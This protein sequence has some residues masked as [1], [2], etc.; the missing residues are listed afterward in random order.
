[1][2]V[3]VCLFVWS[4]PIVEPIAYQSTNLVQIRYLGSS[5]KY[6]ESFFSFSPTPKIKGSSYEKK[7]YK[8]LFSQKRLQR[9]WLNFVSL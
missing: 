4:S 6:L 2:S 1:M 9:F 8:F 3:Y 5:C 7:N